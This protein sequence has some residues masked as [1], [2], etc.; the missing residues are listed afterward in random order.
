MGDFGRCV[1]RGVNSTFLRYSAMCVDASL[2]DGEGE[3]GG[4]EGGSDGEEDGHGVEENGAGEF[5]LECAVVWVDGLIWWANAI[6]FLD[7]KSGSTALGY[8][9]LLLA[10]STVVFGMLP[11]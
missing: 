8:S 7:S 2:G 3:E 11:Y 6:P 5:L 1:N 4:E 9:V 10:L